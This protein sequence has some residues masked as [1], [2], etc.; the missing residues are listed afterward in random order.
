MKLTKAEIT[1]RDAFILYT[2]DGESASFPLTRETVLEMS[3]N[4]SDEALVE[5]CAWLLLRL[6]LELEG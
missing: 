3:V 2:G 5:F 4:C 1:Q 6:P